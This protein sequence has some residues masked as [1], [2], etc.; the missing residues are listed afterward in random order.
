MREA[1][2]I[3]IIRRL[4]AEQAIVKVHDPATAENARPIFSDKISYARNSIEC[5]DNADCCI[6]TTEWQE[7]AMIS[8]RSFL[9]RIRQPI[10]M[11]GRRIYDVN[12]FAQAGVRLL[13][14]GLGP[15]NAP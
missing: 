15:T 9:N 13:A 12:E 8:P 14:I 2:S 7:F 11:D 6:I 10:V 1:V 5:I 3:P 4:V